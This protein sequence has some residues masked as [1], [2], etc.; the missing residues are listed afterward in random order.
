MS[1]NSVA[2]ISSSLKYQ[3]YVGSRWEIPL[4]GV[5]L[6]GQQ[7]PATE[8]TGSSSILSALIDSVILARSHPRYLPR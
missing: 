5:M 7:L 1:Q 3:H 6:D 2:Q 8:L 4:D